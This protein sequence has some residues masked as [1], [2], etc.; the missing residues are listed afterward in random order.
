MRKIKYILINDTDPQNVSDKS[1]SCSF[2]NLGYHYVVGRDTISSPID[3]HKT[4]CFLNQEIRNMKPQNRERLLSCSIGIK[5]NGSLNLST[6][7][8]S[9]RS[10][11]VELLLNLRSHFPM[12]KILATNEIDGD[13]IKAREDMN[14]LRKDLSNYL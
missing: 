13:H 4:G 9:Q 10:S 8:P 6:C 2:L 1:G 11:L 5:Y 12:A 3:I 7:N 14:Q